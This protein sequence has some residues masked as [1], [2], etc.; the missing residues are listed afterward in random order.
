M[1]TTTIT[2]LDFIMLLICLFPIFTLLNIM[3]GV[4]MSGITQTVVSFFNT[5]CVVIPMVYSVYRMTN[6]YQNIASLFTL[7]V[8]ILFSLSICA[9]LC[10]A[11]IP[12]FV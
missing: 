5:I 4:T 10:G 6:G 9:S 7:F 12:L 1:K 2:K 3:N 8:S 11:A